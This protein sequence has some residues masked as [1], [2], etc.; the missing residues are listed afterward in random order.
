MGDKDNR[1]P[2][3]FGHLLFAAVFFAFM[4]LVYAITPAA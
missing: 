1:C 4:W 3:W 2:D